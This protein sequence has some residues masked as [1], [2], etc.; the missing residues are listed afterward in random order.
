[1]R[2]YTFQIGIEVYL[3][4]QSAAVRDDENDMR[5]RVRVAIG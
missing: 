3:V 5:A 4:V 1:M 2:G